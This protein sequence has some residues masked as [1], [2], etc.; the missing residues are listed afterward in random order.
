MLEGNLRDIGE[1][2]LIELQSQLAGLGILRDRILFY[3]SIK[4]SVED[5]ARENNLEVEYVRALYV[6][7]Y[8]FL[9]AKKKEC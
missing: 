2:T 1:E 5:V 7:I 6:Q 8:T 4:K 3:Y 9:E